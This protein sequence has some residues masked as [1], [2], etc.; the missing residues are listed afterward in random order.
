VDVPHGGPS[1]TGNDTFQP[2]VLR[3]YVGSTRF[4][5]ADDLAAFLID[6]LG[7]RA[8]L[9]ATVV[10]TRDAADDTGPAVLLELAEHEDHDPDGGIYPAEYLWGYSDALLGELLLADG[11]TL[12]TRTLP[13]DH[14]DFDLPLRDWE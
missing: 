3:V 6:E 12:V 4:A 9:D 10:D 7:R 11:H 2:P 14:P 8:T 13:P 5:E 1:S